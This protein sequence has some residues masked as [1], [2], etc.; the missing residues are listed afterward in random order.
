M[1]R[2]PGPLQAPGPLLHR[3]RKPTA[4]LE[5]PLTPPRVCA[6][7]SVEC[8]KPS[9]PRWIP[10][11]WATLT[12]SVPSEAWDQPAEGAPQT[13]RMQGGAPARGAVRGT[14]SPP[15]GA[16]A[17]STGAQQG[18][19]GGGQQSCISEWPQQSLCL[20][21]EL[22]YK[23]IMNQKPQKKGTVRPTAASCKVTALKRSPPDCLCAHQPPQGDGPDTRTAPSHGLG[24]CAPER[25]R[26]Q[27]R[28][29]G[30]S[31]CPHAPTDPG[32]TLPEAC[33]LALL[34]QT[35]SPETWASPAQPQLRSLRL[36]ATP[37]SP[38]Q[39]CTAS[40]PAHLPCLSPS[41]TQGSP[42]LLLLRPG[43][44]WE[45]V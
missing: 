3:Q 32:L 24:D 33:P 14:P 13:P 18:G 6:G 4:S 21:S 38:W 11:T 15:K 16:M 40:S 7:R 28:R 23:L 1:R 37:L 42:P 43:L 39:P 19:L 29:A 30:G 25:S 10:A 36:R 17:G 45:V 12:R 41:L 44:H 35:L 8:P 5:N 20:L 27:D 22:H 26:G 34:P 31:L 9:S 2:P